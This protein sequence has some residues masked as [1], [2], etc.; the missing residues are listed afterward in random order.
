MKMSAIPIWLYVVTAAVGTGVICYIGGYIEGRLAALS[1]PA[2]T[3]PAAV[4]LLGPQPVHPVAVS[5]D[6]T[7]ITAGASMQEAQVVAQIAPSP[8]APTVAPPEPPRDEPLGLRI[9]RGTPHT[10]AV[11][12]RYGMHREWYSRGKHP[13]WHCVH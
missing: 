4:P 2:P 12:Q 5:K 10:A 9:A 6:Q 13:Y 11:C 3:L 7:R 8:P 1:P